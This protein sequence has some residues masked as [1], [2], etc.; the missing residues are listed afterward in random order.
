MKNICAIPADNNGN[1]LFIKDLREGNGRTF[2]K[3]R[4]TYNDIPFKETEIYL[5]DGGT[6]FV[7]TTD[8]G[9]VLFRFAKGWV[10]ILRY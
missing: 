1:K 2:V 3:Y 8:D 9:T 10:D 4:S 6:N 5:T 7:I